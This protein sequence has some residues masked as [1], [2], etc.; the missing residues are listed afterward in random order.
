MLREFR[1]GY[2]LRPWVDACWETGGTPQTM[3]VLPDG[4]ADIM[5]DRD[6]DEA[7]VVGTMTAPLVLDAQHIGNY[8]GIRFRPGRLASLLRVPLS[9]LTDARVPLRDVNGR[10]ELRPQ[11]FEQDLTRLLHETD[12]RVDAAIAKI[13]T[14]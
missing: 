10:I 14:S 5:F 3:R 9:E 8:F 2:A 1:P 6:R 7:F 11:S 4:C 12:P 13:V